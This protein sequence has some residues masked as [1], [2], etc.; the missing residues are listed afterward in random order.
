MDKCGGGGIQLTITS[1]VL[2]TPQRRLPVRNGRVHIMLHALLVDAEALESEIPARAIMR[3]HGPRQ[4]QRTLHVE[5][6]HAAL[7]DR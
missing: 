1:Q 3:L 2:D 5:M 6:R 7:H 4:K